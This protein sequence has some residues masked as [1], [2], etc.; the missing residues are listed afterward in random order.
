MIE[1]EHRLTQRDMAFLNKLIYFDYLTAKQLV[2]AGLF[3][4]EKKARDRLRL[5]H[6]AEYLEYCL[7]PYLGPGRS[8]YV[9]HLSSKRISEIAGLLG[10]VREEICLVRPVYSPVLLHHLAINEFI[11]SLQ[12]ACKRSGVYE[13][14]IIP[15]YRKLAG[16]GKLKKATSQN[17]VVRGKEVELIPDGVVCLSRGNAKT[18]LFFEIYRGSQALE[19]EERSIR[20]KLEVYAAYCDQKLYK[21]F[22]E[23]FS[24]PFAGFRVL[25]IVS[26]T[27]YLEK[28]KKICSELGHIGLFWL[29]LEKDISSDTIFKP[30][31]QVPGEEMLKAIVNNKDKGSG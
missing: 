14:T 11:I 10:C 4:N 26:S 8:E 31:W 25:M 22:S 18:L 16:R 7:K 27:S 21:N 17:V 2:S 28:L 15:E 3:P 24:Y 23:L 29:A 5:L 19:G 30:I 9:Y 1:M 20:N 13:A 6:Q 12:N